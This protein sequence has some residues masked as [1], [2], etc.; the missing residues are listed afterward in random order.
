[1]QVLGR[2]DGSF[3]VEVAQRT[4]PARSL[5]SVGIGADCSIAAIR[6]PRRSGLQQQA[7]RL[8]ADLMLGGIGAALVLLVGL[9]LPCLYVTGLW[10][11]CRRWRAV[12]SISLPSSRNG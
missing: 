10:M 6:A 8:H 2:P 12:Q 9:A 7:Q 4:D 5:A 11:A 1:M 3:V